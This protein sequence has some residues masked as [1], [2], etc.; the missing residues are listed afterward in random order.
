MHTAEPY[1][2]GRGI[3]DVTGEIAEIGM[4][5][6]G[7]IDQQANGL[8]TRLRC[9]AFVLADP[10]TSRRVLIVVVDACMIFDSVHRE[11]LRRL[12]ERYGGI[13]DESNVMLTATHT[14]CGPSGH[15]H[16]LLY[17]LTTFGFHRKTFNAMTEGIVESVNRAHADLAPSSLT[18]THDELTTASVNRSRIAFDRNPH[19]DRRHFPDAIDPQTSLL[20]I[21]RRGTPVGAINW[22][23][24]HATSMSGDNRLISSDNKGYAAYHWERDVHGVEYRGDPAPSFIAAFAQTNAGDMSPNRDL[25]PPGTPEDLPRTAA[26]GTEQYEAAAAQLTKP[27][28]DLSGGIDSRLIYVDMSDV[29]V[30]PEFTGDGKTHRTGKPA[31]GA[32]MPAGSL[33]DGPGFPLFT[34]GVNPFW[35]R[36][37]RTALYKLSPALAASQAPKGIFAPAGVM[38]KVYPWLQEVV[39]VQLLRI[40]ELYLIGIPGEVTITAGLRLRR[41]VSEVVGAE[42]R[43]VLVAGYS[44]SY[45][46][47]VTTP[48]EYDAQRY[49]GGSTLFG[50]WELP[51]LQQI[52]AGLATAMRDGEDTALG[53]KPPDLSGKQI[54]LQPGVVLDT[55][56]TGRRFGDVL[57][58]P[59]DAYAAGDAVTAAFAGAHPSNDLHRGGT[60]LE[61]QRWSG[62]EWVT[63][64][65][66]GDWSTALRWERRGVSASRVTITWQTP[67]DADGEY[68]IRYRGDAKNI[69]GGVR[70]ITGVTRAFTVT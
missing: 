42:L 66:D 50:R 11:V 63:I 67:G 60:Y 3:A 38:N 45:F 41:T 23:P 55:P 6:Y 54:R 40:G 59:A 51:A 16:H 18:L 12:G 62:R 36:V 9:R 31:A 4:L 17:N 53:S 58:A 14:H 1:L 34:E 69:L 32:S 29:E 47:Y 21:E 13:Y 46:H 27:G 61:V 7:R 8:H 15:S 25:T 22:F 68:R 33:T 57:R 35:D 37:S 48:E 44:N 56:P 39:P 26:N 10:E 70:A 52:A 28:I 2:V 64:A 65:D 30:R 49:E 43:N 19:E 5:G 20:R 24:C